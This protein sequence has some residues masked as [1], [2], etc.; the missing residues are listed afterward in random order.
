MP[1]AYHT[2]MALTYPVAL[3]FAVPFLC[4]S[5]RGTN[6]GVHH[7][8]PA[9]ADGLDA[10]AITLG[11]PSFVPSAAG[12]AGAGGDGAA[13]SR[14]LANR[15]FFVALERPGKP[16]QNPN[17]K[18][19][20]RSPGRRRRQRVPFAD[21][22]LGVLIGRGA[23]GKVYRG[24]YKGEQVAVKVRAGA[25]AA[26]D[27]VLGHACGW[28]GTLQSGFDALFWAWRCFTAC[29]EG[30]AAHVYYDHRPLG[31]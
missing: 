12:G 9:T 7:D 11:V 15:F 10:D 4:C 28:E 18:G 20:G 27:A 26:R 25:C 17:P 1:C 29:S 23:Y 14:P 5:S 22:E 21:L 30:L 16:S 24:I 13:A 2:T 6:T 3:R 19:K 8:R 31:L